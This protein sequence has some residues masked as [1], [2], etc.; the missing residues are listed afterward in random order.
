MKP[1]DWYFLELCDVVAS[2][3]RMIRYAHILR[4]YKIRRVL[5]QY[6]LVIVRVFVGLLAMDLLVFLVLTSAA[7]LLRV[8]CQ[9]EYEPSRQIPTVLSNTCLVHSQ[10]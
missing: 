1:N 3:H 4:G 6:N 9:G 7:C 2:K 8:N 10:H 5:S